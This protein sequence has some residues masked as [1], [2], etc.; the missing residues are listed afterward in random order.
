VVVEEMVFA[1]HSGLRYLVL[2]AGVA[3][4]V[5]ALVG[6]RRGGTPGGL[7]RVVA[8]VFVS[9]LDLQ[10]LLGLVLLALW[11]FYGQ[12]IGHL[13]MMG[14]ALVVAHVGSVMARRRAASG[15]ASRVRFIAILATLALIV[16]GILA[17][18]RPVL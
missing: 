6:W 9:V 4:A 7:E 15:G 3:A 11:P 17:I 16:G 1:A 14:A 10:V 12:L 8:I 5:A 2:L 18:G 13:V